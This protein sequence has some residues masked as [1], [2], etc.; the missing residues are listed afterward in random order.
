MTSPFCNLLKAQGLCAKCYLKRTAILY[1]RKV[2]NI[3]RH[4]SFF[5]LVLETDENI[6]YKLNHDL[7]T[8][9]F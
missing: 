8:G 4:G 2:E 7:I 5:S 9:E 3:L 6:E 1:N